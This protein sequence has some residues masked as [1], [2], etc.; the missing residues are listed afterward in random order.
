MNSYREVSSRCL[1]HRN[2]NYLSFF[3]SVSLIT[4]F[5]PNEPTLLA[6]TQLKTRKPNHSSIHLLIHSSTTGTQRRRIS[7]YKL[8]HIISEFKYLVH[9]RHVLE[10]YVIRKYKVTLVITN[11]TTF[12]IFKGGMSFG[13]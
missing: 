7:R 11:V 13:M 10:Y 6:H 2:T 8:T 1:Q 9:F 5:V 12:V 4:F 3:L